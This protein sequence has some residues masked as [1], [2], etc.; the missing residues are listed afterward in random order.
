MSNFRVPS[1]SK[2]LCFDILIH[3]FMQFDILIHFFLHM[4]IFLS[5]FPSLKQIADSGLLRPHTIL[6]QGRKQREPIFSKVEAKRVV[7]RASLETPGGKRAVGPEPQRKMA[8]WNRDASVEMS[9]K[10]QASGGSCPEVQS[11]LLWMVTVIFP[12]P[13]LWSKMYPHHTTPQLRVRP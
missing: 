3:F 1:R 12:R 11:Q 8:Q 10:S 2:V 5:R 7:L 6:R 9:P 4:Y 13:P